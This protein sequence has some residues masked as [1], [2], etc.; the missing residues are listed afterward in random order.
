MH[1]AREGAGRVLAG[2]DEQ[3]EEGEE[4]GRGHGEDSRPPPFGGGPRNVP[5][6][7]WQSRLLPES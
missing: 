7:P 5:S 3:R 1:G 2:C 4:R 6:A